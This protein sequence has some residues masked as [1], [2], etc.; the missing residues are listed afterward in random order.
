MYQRTLY[1]TMHHALFLVSLLLL[2]PAPGQGAGLQLF[3]ALRNDFMAVVATNGMLY[4]NIL[5]NRLELRYRAR[6]WKFYTDARLYYFSG[7]MASM[8]NE[9]S[10]VVLRSFV[11]YFSGFGHLTLGKTYVNFG[12]PG[13]FNPF[14][15]NKDINLSDFQYAKEGLAALESDF[16]FGG[17]SGLK[18]Y[19]SP[20][21]EVFKTGV[22]LYGTLLGFDGGLVYNRKDRDVNVAGLYLKGDV[23]LGLSAS[24][25]L[26][27]DDGLG[28]SYVESRLGLD[29]SLKD[30]VFGLVWYHNSAGAGNKADYGNRIVQDVYYQARN[31]LYN[32]ITWKVDEF[33][34]FELHGFFNLTD[35]SGILLPQVGYT[36]A[37][38]LKTALQLA[39]VY[40]GGQTEFSRDSFGTLVIL[41]RVETKF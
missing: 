29:Y 17:R 5:E 28:S 26:H 10:L 8:T 39:W 33:L 7:E 37:N 9:T 25:A 6:D 1:R 41:F 14:E 22:A 24:L 35:G 21:E 36:I 3:G 23:E 19:V 30:L 4:S 12:N 18:L 20:Q 40:A 11:R 15:S 2:T 38:G 16:A 31:Y 27:F 13:L 32:Y 34:H